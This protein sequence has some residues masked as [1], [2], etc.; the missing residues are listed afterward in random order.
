M[1]KAETNQVK[2]VLIQ[3]EVFPHEKEDLEKWLIGKFH[4]ISD[5]LREVI[6]HPNN[7]QIE[8]QEKIS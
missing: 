2:K 6:R 1:A 5:F 4:S 3:V 8:S 7:V